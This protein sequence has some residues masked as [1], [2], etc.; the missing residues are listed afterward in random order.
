MSITNSPCHRLP[1]DQPVDATTFRVAFVSVV[2]EPNSV[3]NAATFSVIITNAKRY[4]PIASPM[5]RCIVITATSHNT[6]VFGSQIKNGYVV[7]RRQTEM[8]R[9]GNKCFQAIS[10]SGESKLNGGRIN[11]IQILVPFHQPCSCTFR[12]ATKEVNQAKVQLQNTPMESLQM[13]IFS[14]SVP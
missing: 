9:I 10:V 12:D 4:N 3:P 14:R 7:S 11:A 5:A 1:L 13:I 2:I 8:L 6:R